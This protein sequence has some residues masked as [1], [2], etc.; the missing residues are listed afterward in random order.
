MFGGSGK[1]CFK[2]VVYDC[3]LITKPYEFIFCVVCLIVKQIVPS[4]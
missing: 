1:N 2:F 4:H 3:F